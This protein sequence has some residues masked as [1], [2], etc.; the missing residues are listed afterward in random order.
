MEIGREEKS[1]MVQKDNIKPG[2]TIWYLEPY[3]SLVV[4]AIVLEAPK[5]TTIDGM[6]KEYVDVRC[7]ES[8]GTTCVLLEDA[9]LTRDDVLEDEKRK[10]EEY[11]KE[12]D[13][14]IHSIS[15]LLQFAYSNTVSIAEEYTNW[16]A[17]AA[18]KEIAK[19]RFW[20]ELV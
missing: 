6:K 11:I 20:I 12:V 17:R 5:T 15:D 16:Y 1:F 3:S 14:Q 4:S 7:I 9:F 13:A 2:M 8:V 18:V 10:Q 19:K